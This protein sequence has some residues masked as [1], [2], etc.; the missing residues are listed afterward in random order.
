MRNQ[1]PTEAAVSSVDGAQSSSALPAADELSVDEAALVSPAPPSTLLFTLL[2]EYKL[3]QEY[4]QP[5]LVVSYFTDL[6]L[7]KSIVLLQKLKKVFL[8]AT[9]FMAC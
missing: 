2:A 6:V 1:K 9:A 3:R 5:L 4:A 8:R 7:S